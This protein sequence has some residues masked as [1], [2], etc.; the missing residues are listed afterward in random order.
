[1]KIEGD[2]RN[3]VPPKRVASLDYAIEVTIGDGD[4]CRPGTYVFHQRT[5]ASVKRPSA[6]GHQS[7]QWQSTDPMFSIIDEDQEADNF[8]CC[9]SVDNRLRWVTGKAIERFGLAAAFNDHGIE[10]SSVPSEEG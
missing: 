5:S 3:F 8:L 4:F 6:V 7:P 10:V 2:G 9:R 1:M